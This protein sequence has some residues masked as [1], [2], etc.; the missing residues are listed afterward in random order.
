MKTCNYIF[1]F[2]TTGAFLWIWKVIVT[3]GVQQRYVIV[4]IYTSTANIPTKL[5]Y[6]FLVC[7]HIIFSP[8]NQ[9]VLF[10]LLSLFTTNQIN[11]I[12]L[13]KSPV[14]CDFFN[15]L[16]LEVAYIL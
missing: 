2:I 3:I 14:F 4:F 13:Y 7:Q 11:G 5:F 9:S 12:R 6:N 15:K 16:F 1:H 8:Q 10:F